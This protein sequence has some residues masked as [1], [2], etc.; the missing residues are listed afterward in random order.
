MKSLKVYQEWPLKAYYKTTSSHTM[1]LPNRELNN[2]M[3]LKCQP[4]NDQL[5]NL[6]KN[7]DYYLFIMMKTYLDH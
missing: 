1:T 2:N 6:N 3:F 4:N 5:S 7:Y